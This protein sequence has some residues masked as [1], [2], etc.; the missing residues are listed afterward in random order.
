M[1]PVSSAT[2]NTTPLPNVRDSLLPQHVDKLATIAS[3]TRPWALI[4]RS[5]NPSDG[6]RSI[7]YA[8]LSNAVNRAAWWLE[9]NLLAEK[10]AP[11]AYL[12]PNDIRYAILALATIKTRRKVSDQSQL[13]QLEHLV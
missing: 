1:A 13:E 10:D 8:Q 7:S 11:C 9:A 2:T 6:F 5:A 3:H 4:G 12:G